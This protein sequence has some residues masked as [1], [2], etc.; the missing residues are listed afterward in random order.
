MHCSA[1]CSYTISRLV[2]ALGVET[3]ALVLRSDGWHVDYPPAAVR[4]TCPITGATQ[5]LQARSS[6]VIQFAP[7]GKFLQAWGGP[8]KGAPYQ[9]FNRGGLHSAFTECQSCTSERRLN[10]STE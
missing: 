2:P 8:V 3:A 4:C 1:R 9:W 5:E 7:D 10:R 6:F